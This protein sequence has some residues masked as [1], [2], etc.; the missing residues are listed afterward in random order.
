MRLEFQ[1]TNRRSIAVKPVRG[2]G[3]QARKGDAERPWRASNGVGDVDFQFQKSLT[4][5][6][7]LTGADDVAFC[8]RVT[9]AL[10]MGWSLYGFARR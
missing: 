3:N 2:A 4:V 10:S 8:H 9:Q 6:R 7:Y 1:R 5:Y